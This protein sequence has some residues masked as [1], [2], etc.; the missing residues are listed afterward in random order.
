MM[1]LVN[2]FYG[3]VYRNANGT[4]TVFNA[5]VVARGLTRIRIKFM[6]AR[7]FIVFRFLFI[8]QILRFVLI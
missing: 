5:R 1:L 8:R 2:Q 3:I 4:T 6:N 7:G